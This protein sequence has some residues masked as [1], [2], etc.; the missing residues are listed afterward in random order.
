MRLLYAS[1]WMGPV[2]KSLKPSCLGR[3][4]GKKKLAGPGPSQNFVFRLRP[5]RARAEI[6]ISLSGRSGLGPKFQFL[7]RAGPIFS[8]ILRAGPGPVRKIRPVQISS[9]D[10]EII[11]ISIGN[12]KVCLDL[13]VIFVIFFFWRQIAYL[14]SKILFYIS[15]KQKRKL[16]RNI[17]TNIPSLDYAT[18]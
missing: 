12:K 5:G 16:H 10:N 7:F 4:R 15:M 6:S 2:L 9:P 13:I 18:K 1:N 11:I 3:N 17:I 14:I 8:Y